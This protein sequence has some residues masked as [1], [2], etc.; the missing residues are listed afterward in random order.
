VKTDKEIP[1]KIHFSPLLRPDSKE[2]AQLTY[3]FAVPDS[4]CAKLAWL[5]WTSPAPSWSRS[6]NFSK[7]MSKNDE[8]KI[9]IGQPNER[10][11]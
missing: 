9:L 7:K 2:A 6:W 8:I 5:R 10:V 11:D 4:S 1:P 3:L